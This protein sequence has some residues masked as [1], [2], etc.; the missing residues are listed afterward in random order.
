MILVI[1]LPSARLRDADHRLQLHPARLPRRF[2]SADRGT[3]R[4][5]ARRDRRADVALGST[6]HAQRGALRELV[7]P[8]QPRQRTAGAAGLQRRRLRGTRCEEPDRGRTWLGA[9]PPAHPLRPLRRAAPARPDAGL[10]PG[11]GHPAGQPARQEPLRVLGRA[12]H[13]RAQRPARARGRRRARACAAEPRLR[14][15]LQVGQA[16]EAEG[17]HRHPGVRGLEGRALQDHQLL[18][19]ARARADEPLRHHEPHRR[20]RRAAGLRRRGYAF[21]ADASDADTLVFRRRE[22]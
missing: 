18:R 20:G 6:L 2:R 9:G 13:R 1:S 12:H 21:A 22:E 4:E 7:A 10:P 3:A 16:Q 5:I 19:Q 17:A 14:R 15:V 8:I 11:D